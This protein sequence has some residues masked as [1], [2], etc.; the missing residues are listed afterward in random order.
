MLYA[1]AVCESEAAESL[2]LY[3]CFVYAATGQAE[4]DPISGQFRQLYHTSH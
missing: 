2:A 3:G 1:F 4:L